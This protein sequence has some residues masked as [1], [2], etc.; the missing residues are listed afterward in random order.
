M[1]IIILFFLLTFKHAFVDLFVQS[2]HNQIKKVHYLGGWPH[3][4]EHAIGTF[5]VTL[6]AWRILGVTNLQLAILL[7]VIDGVAH[8]HIDW[9]KHQVLKYYEQRTG[10]P[11]LE[12]R[13]NVYWLV[14]CVDQQLHF[15]TYA[16]LCLIVVGHS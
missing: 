8:W 12:H 5:I 2:Y 4:T 1:E 14:Q 6:C 3:Y 9:L 13:K 7:A 15:I 16:S 10:L 11:M